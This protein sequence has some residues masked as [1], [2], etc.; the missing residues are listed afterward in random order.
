MPL[1]LKAY[2]VAGLIFAILD[3]VW[4]GLV[5]RGFYAS[6]MGDLMRAKFSIVPAVAFYVI[7]VAGLVV[8]AVLPGVEAGSVGRAA[9]LGGLLGLVAYAAYD[10]SN[11][12]T[13]K[14]W[15][16][17]LAMLDLAWGPALSAA[18]AAAAVWVLRMI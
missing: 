3:G 9:L 18:S 15:P 12:A 1:E 17:P 14:N 8:F 2:L 5:A 7:Y 4:L 11:L 6:Q 13:L 16:A 10:L